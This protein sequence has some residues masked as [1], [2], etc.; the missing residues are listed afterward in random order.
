M[1][2]IREAS[3]FLKQSRTGLQ[4]R[5]WIREPLTILRLEWRGGYVECDWLMRSEK[6]ASGKPANQHSEQAFQDALDLRDLV[7]E[8]FPAVM[9][10]QLK[11]FRATADHRLELVMSGE[12]QRLEPTSPKVLPLALRAR[13]AGFQFELA[14]GILIS[15]S[16]GSHRMPAKAPSQGI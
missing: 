1:N 4:R 12:V 16:S 6:T 13:R 11:M 3:R 14:D 9:Q 10:A 5:R 7:F 2:L 15:P 8:F